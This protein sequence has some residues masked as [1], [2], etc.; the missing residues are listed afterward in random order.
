VPKK[1][2]I[3]VVGIDTSDSL[4]LVLSN[5]TWEENQF[6]KRLQTMNFVA[7]KIINREKGDGKFLVLTGSLHAETAQGIAGLSQILRCPNVVI[8][9]SEETEI[10]KDSKE[11]IWNVI[12]L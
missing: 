10:R 4:Q 11:E 1:A 5:D 12:C 7:Q 8:L 6:Q 9:D 2:G 3:R